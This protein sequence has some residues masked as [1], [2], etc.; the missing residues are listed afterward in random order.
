M[1]ESKNWFIDA[2][3]HKPKDFYQLL[4]VYYKDIISKEKLPA[5]YILMNN[6]IYENYISVFES[7]KCL[8]SQNNTISFN[9]ETITSDSENALILAINECFPQ[10][11]RIGCYYHYLNDLKK[12]FKLYNLI[13]KNNFTDIMKELSYLPLTYKGDIKFFDDKI[14]SLKKNYEDFNNFINNY[15]IKNKRRFF[16]SKDFDY[17]NIPQDIRSNSYIETYNKFIKENLGKKRM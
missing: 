9:V 8:I 1:R 13:K 14:D 16:I 10:V 15:F 3:F 7:I 6:K 12:N 17:Y 5:L 4:I 11:Q 2:T